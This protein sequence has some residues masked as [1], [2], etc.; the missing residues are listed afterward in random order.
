MAKEQIIYRLLSMET[1][2]NQMKL[3]NGKLSKLHW[4]KLSKVFKILIKLPLFLN[5]QSIITTQL[6]R[7]IL[8]SLSSKKR[9]IG[10]DFFENTNTGSFSGAFFLKLA[11]NTYLKVLQSYSKF[12]LGTLRDQS[13]LHRISSSGFS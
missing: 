4:N 7:S 3:K 10:I 5:D 9:K 12:S 6:I 2:I 8:K 1:N 13:Q 11:A